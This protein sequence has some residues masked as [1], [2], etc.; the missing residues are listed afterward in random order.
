MRAVLLSLG[1]HI[2]IAGLIFGPWLFK[3]QRTPAALP[4]AMTVQYI[5]AAEDGSPR[6]T[7][8]SDT[9][10]QSSPPQQLGQPSRGSQS[11]ARPSTSSI[12]AAMPDKDA[13]PLPAKPILNSSS[14]PRTVM[15]AETPAAR[16]ASALAP[17]P[18]NAANPG[19]ASRD[20]DGANWEQRL[21]AVL[22]R[23]KRYPASA[24]RAGMED[25]IYLRIRIDRIGRILAC[26]IDQSHKLPP[27]DEAALQLV[28]S[29]A[30][31]PPPPPSVIG[32]EVEF[33]I[34]VTYSLNETSH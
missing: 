3:P 13:I 30:P 2:A 31:L 33:V 1:G 15:L 8:A 7:R 17:A 16:P 34:P 11:S 20:I 22:T 10:G 4:A 9:A 26:I 21:L 25:T 28:H 19:P 18:A 32:A 24:R 6:H 14:A 27:L 5:E 23:K 29:A 12:P